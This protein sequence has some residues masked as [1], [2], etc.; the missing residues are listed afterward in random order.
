M[1][2]LSVE[3]EEGNEVEGRRGTVLMRYECAGS[4]VRRPLEFSIMIIKGDI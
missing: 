4:R 2:L 3:C 1:K